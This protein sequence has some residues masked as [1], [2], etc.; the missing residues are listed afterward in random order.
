M[1]TTD[2]SSHNKTSDHQHRHRFDSMAYQSSNCLPVPQ[3][4]C[5]NSPLCPHNRSTNAP[6]GSSN[7]T[8]CGS[9]RQSSPATNTSLG[10]FTAPVLAPTKGPTRPPMKR[11]RTDRTSISPDF[12]LDDKPELN[13]TND[14]PSQT[15]ST[16]N[17]KEKRLPHH[18]IE[19]RYRENLNSQ[20]EALRSAVPST[21]SCLALDM[22]D[23][24][25]AAGSNAI[26]PLSK[27]GVIAHAAEYMRQVT[28]QNEEMEWQIA[29]LRITAEALQRLVNC[30]D[31]GVVQRIVDAGT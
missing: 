15:S 27:A 17:N 22:E 2:T 4:D 14:R 23:I 31:C 1:S 26:R 21:S 20:I 12:D 7:K 10:D 5:W 8:H 30:E 16:S 6:P 24:G 3:T 11:A 29:Q 25:A 19:R 9:S 13:I 28:Q 18:V